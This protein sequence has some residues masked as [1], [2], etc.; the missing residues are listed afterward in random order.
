VI[1]FRIEDAHIGDEVLHVVRRERVCVRCLVSTVRI[2][3]GILV[4]SW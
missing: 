2:E 3:W 1:C 4:S